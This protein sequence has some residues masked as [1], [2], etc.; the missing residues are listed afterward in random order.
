MTIDQLRDRRREL[1]DRKKQE[2]ERQ[3]AGHGDNM[4]LFM[5]QEELMDV[6]AQLRTLMPR[7]RIGHR[8]SD[9]DYAPNRQ[10]YIDWDRD[11][12]ALDDEIEDGRK[13]MLQ[14]VTQS[15][16][17]LSP[18]Q[19][20]IL[21]L[22]QAGLSIKAIAAKLGLNTSTVSRTLR[23]AKARVLAETER[24]MQQ[25]RLQAER[26]ACLDMADPATALVILA[27]LTAKQ[28]VYLYLYYAEWLSL[29]EIAALT[30]TDHSTILRTIQRALRNIGVVLG[31]QV[32]VLENRDALDDLA[33]RLYCEIRDIDSIVPEGHRPPREPPREPSPPPERE[34][35]EEMAEP[36]P[37]LTIRTSS[38]R[39][40]QVQAIGRHRPTGSARRGKLLTALLDRART[41]ARDGHPVYCWLVAV[42]TSITRRDRGGATKW[43][44]RIFSREDCGS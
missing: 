29:R 39:S 17:I 11:N 28:A 37:P 26:P 6:N 30:G 21:D 44:K 7:H 1:L 27:A 4:A 14:A 10:Q 36:R 19:R 41:Q 42:F 18:R 16:D 20:E 3:A 22:R 8:R 38:G 34:R 5:V 23:R 15:L 32:S 13:A 31:Y 24:A 40:E 25:R 12:M 33:Y 2:Q 9:G 35:R 43:L